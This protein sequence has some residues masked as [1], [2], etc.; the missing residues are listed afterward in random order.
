MSDSKP[1]DKPNSSAQAA[2]VESEAS[3]VYNLNSK[4]EDTNKT[5]DNGDDTVSNI[6]IP[7]KNL[8]HITTPSEPPL[9]T[10]RN[11]F[12]VPDTDETDEWYK[13]RIQ[14]IDDYFIN[15]N[16]NTKG[17]PF[18]DMTPNMGHCLIINITT[19][20]SESLPKRM[21][22]TNDS[23]KLIRI[24]VK[25]GFQC[26]STQTDP[27]N[28]KYT[29]SKVKTIL[30]QYTDEA[31]HKDKSSFVLFFMS[32][33]ETDGT[34]CCYDKSISVAEIIKMFQDCN[35]LKGK[36][37]LFFFQECRGKGENEATNPY[38]S[39]YLEGAQ[40]IKPPKQR[41]PQYSDI[42][43]AYSSTHVD[44]M[45]DYGH[46]LFITA[47]TKVLELTALPSFNYSIGRGSFDKEPI[48]YDIFQIMT[49]VGACMADLDCFEDL[50]TV[51]NKEV[52]DALQAYYADLEEEHF[53]NQE[54]ARKK[55]QRGI[56]QIIPYR[57][58]RYNI[59]TETIFQL[60]LDKLKLY[61]DKYEL[62]KEDLY[63]E[64]EKLKNSD[65]SQK[66]C[67]QIPEF[68]SCLRKGFYF[69]VNSK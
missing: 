14:A 20:E 22:A 18:Y 46:S 43:I 68:T 63:T 58:K 37:K 60:V 6:L 55:I 17:M 52:I 26:H 4:E 9:E 56:R 48:N 49:L 36:P 25:L 32:H 21:C 67:K 10:H 66:I 42:F 34:I 65:C 45:D 64:I 27:D 47:L 33:G 19:F 31:M 53:S 38:Q 59:E 57:E 11:H 5:A 13:M 30:A 1:D 61:A 40:K 69:K 23:N 50:Q 3:K 28:S 35:S 39:N 8:V 12:Q 51:D 16:I 2:S 54:S 62:T 7:F 44:Y 41:I 15:K 29:V 24:M